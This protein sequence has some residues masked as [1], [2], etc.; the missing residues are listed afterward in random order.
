MRPI[1]ATGGGTWWSPAVA[2]LSSRAPPGSGRQDP[3]PPR[4]TAPDH[5]AW[6]GGKSP[7]VV[8]AGALAEAGAAVCGDA[9]IL[10]GFSGEASGPDWSSRAN[11]RPDVL[12]SEGSEDVPGDQSVHDL[13]LLHVA[14]GCHG[15]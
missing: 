1:I 6:L 9:F 13:E 4:S 7:R 2:I 14:G 12:A 8:L 3:S 5:K 15:L 10:D 11:D